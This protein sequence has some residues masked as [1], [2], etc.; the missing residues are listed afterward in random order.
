MVSNISQEPGT[1]NTEHQLE[2]EE[3]S[4]TLESN[5]RNFLL[6]K[7]VSNDNGITII[8]PHDLRENFKNG[9]G[10]ARN[11][12]DQST[13]SI[14]EYTLVYKN[15]KR[16]MGTNQ[17]GPRSFKCISKAL[18]LED[19]E[20]CTKI[21]LTADYQGSSVL[22]ASNEHYGPASNMIKTTV[23]NFND[24]KRDQ[25]PKENEEGMLVIRE[26]ILEIMLISYKQ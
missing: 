17:R 12:D 22:S 18:C 19:T 25:T 10:S 2:N 15:E 3:T 7:N 9:N 5:S 11:N 13:T 4:N 26:I 1:S 16:E 20:F 21:E 14:T 23:S 8:E 6:Y 24:L